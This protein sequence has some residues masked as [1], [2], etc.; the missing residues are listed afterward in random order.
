MMHR[1]VIED[2]LGNAIDELEAQL[3]NEGNL[4]QINKTKKKQLIDGIQMIR[5]FIINLL[6]EVTGW[7]SDLYY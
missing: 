1:Q 2:R 5:K 6:S 4:R 7:H 3:P